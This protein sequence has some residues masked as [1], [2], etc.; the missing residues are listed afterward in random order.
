[1]TSQDRKKIANIYINPET[2]QTFKKLAAH[3]GST[4]QASVANFLEENQR[5]VQEMVQALD[6]IKSGKDMGMVLQ[7]LLAKGLQMTGENLMINDEGNE[8]ATD[9]RQSD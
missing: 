5:A 9:N 8:N 1:M 3:Q 2:H 4:I 7:N 6:D